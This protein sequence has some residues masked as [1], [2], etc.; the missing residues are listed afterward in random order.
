MA[1]LSHRP[2]GTHTVLESVRSGTIEPD[3]AVAVL[4]YA[5][6]PGEAPPSVEALEQFLRDLTEENDGTLP[7][8]RE[9]ID[10][11]LCPDCGHLTLWDDKLED[12]RHLV[13]NSACWLSKGD[14]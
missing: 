10:C 7:D 9:W 11:E 14:C 12:H 5:Y 4:G 2:V 1:E 13:P 8:D 6:A 3:D